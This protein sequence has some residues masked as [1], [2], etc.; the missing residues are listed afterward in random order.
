MGSGDKAERFDF[1]IS[2]AGADQ[3]WAEWIGQQLVDAG[4]TIE[5][6]V[7]HWAAGTHFVAAMQAALE[8]ADRVL[9]V[10]S[11]AYFTHAYAQA[12]HASAFASTVTDRPGRIVPV[13]IDECDV[14]EL[15][16]SLTRIELAGLGEADAARRLLKGVVPA[17]EQPTRLVKFPG[18]SMHTA[19]GEVEFPRRL[20]PVWN[21][22]A[23]NPFFTGRAGFLAT[24]DRRLRRTAERE[25]GGPV[26]VVPMQGMGGVG[27]TT[28]GKFPSR[29]GVM[30]V[31]TVGAVAG[32]R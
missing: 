19:A 7:W 32:A 24:L 14:P 12:E 30:C 29:T 17:P 6:D 16:A 4:Y 8:R 25:Q 21:V 18:P 20:P 10:Y 2:H 13:R 3:Q 15:Y 11:A 31:T 23:R 1:F 27:K 5:L 26:A 28:P 9:A 22:P